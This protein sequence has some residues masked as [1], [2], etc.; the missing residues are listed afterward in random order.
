M[1]ACSL[2]WGLAWPDVFYAL[3]DHVSLAI[4]PGEM[5][6]LVGPSGAGKSTLV[7]LACRFYD[8]NAGA[9]LVDGVDIRSYALEEYRRNIGIEEVGNAAAYLGSDLS[10]GVTGEVHYVDA[11]YNIVG[12]PIADDSS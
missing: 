4:E 5:I 9:I 6:G 1:S 12:L 11:G 3:L 2:D 8:V 7:N 10:A